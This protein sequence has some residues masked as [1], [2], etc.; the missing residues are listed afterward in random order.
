[1]QETVT[2]HSQLLHYLHPCYVTSLHIQSRPKNVELYYCAYLHQLLINFYNSF[3]GTLCK[4]YAITW[5]LH[6]PPHHKCV[7][8]LPCE[9]KIKYEHIYNDN[10]WCYQ[11]CVRCSHSVMCGKFRCVVC[12]TL[13]IVLQMTL[14]VCVYVGMCVKCGRSVMGEKSRCVALEQLFHVD[15]FRCTA[16]SQ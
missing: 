6:I 2:K 13:D 11:V 12:T 10:Q 4:Q 16:C 5:L 1:M 3:T 14:C 15:C 9:L 8:T 7:S